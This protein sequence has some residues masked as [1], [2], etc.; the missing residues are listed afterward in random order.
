MG[1][2]DKVTATF[3]PEA[4]V[5]YLDG[6]FDPMEVNY[7]GWGGTHRTVTADMDLGVGVFRTAQYGLRRAIWD[8]AFGYVSGFRKRDIAYYIVTRSLSERIANRVM[9]RESNRG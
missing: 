6:P 3:Y 7:L 8:A 5:T 1:A 2:N 9:A 4:Q